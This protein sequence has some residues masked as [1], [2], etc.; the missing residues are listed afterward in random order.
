M[1]QITLDNK[2]TINLKGLKNLVHL[3]DEKKKLTFLLETVR[4]NGCEVVIAK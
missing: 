1:D 3:D 4:A 2:I